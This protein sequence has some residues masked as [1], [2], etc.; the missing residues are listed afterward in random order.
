MKAV[1]QVFVTPETRARDAVGCEALHLD[2]RAR[3]ARVWQTRQR[4][5]LV[6]AA[7][8]ASLARRLEQEGASAPLLA[9]ARRA[10]ADEQ[11][12]AAR[13]AEL[14]H[15]FGAPRL[16]AMPTPEAPRLGPKATAK[17]TLLYELVAMSCITETLSTTLLGAL[18]EQAEPGR[19]KDVMREILRDEVWHA[20][21]GWAYLAEVRCD[22]A[23]RLIAAYLPAM[24]A[25]TVSDELF[26]AAEEPPEVQALIGVGQLPR[27]LRRE[28]FAATVREVIFPG[29]ARFGVDP[30]AGE[31]WLERV[32]PMRTIPFTPGTPAIEVAGRRD[33]PA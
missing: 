27:P 5:E 29:L 25:A 24:L 10:I 32:A 30:R 14:A 11:R 26:D 31:R 33:V 21:L 2:R 16:S 23:Q 20:R 15:H 12:H 19:P 9:L 18:V 6:A 22:G 28:I 17:V 1:A 4:F 8:F 13:C 3:A 7:R